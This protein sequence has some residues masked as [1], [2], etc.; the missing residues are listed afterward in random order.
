MFLNDQFETYLK[1][2]DAVIGD[3]KQRCVDAEELHSK[4]GVGKVF[5]EWMKARIVQEDLVIGVDFNHSQTGVVRSGRGTVNKS[6]Y[7][8]TLEAAKIIASME[9]NDAGRK[10]RKWL[11]RVE[12]QA[13]QQAAQPNTLSEI[14]TARKYLAALEREHAA[15]EEKKR[16]QLV[17][18]SNTLYPKVEPEAGKLRISIKDIKAEFAPYLAESKI[19][20]VLRFYGQ[21]RTRFQFGTHENAAFQTFQRDGLDE[22]FTRFIEDAT[23]RISSSKTSVIL[24]HE[25]FDGEAARIP[26]DV[27]VEHLGFRRRRLRR[28]KLQPAPGTCTPGVPFLIQPERTY[29]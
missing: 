15:N 14:E 8:L 28:L 6:V 29:Q 1:L 9:R 7:T 17:I 16:L 3:R 11:V 27:A 26:L 10:I 13:R 22:V 21:G 19:R 12:D 25:C 5:T 4:L 23:Y 20:L 2:F 18:A 24:E